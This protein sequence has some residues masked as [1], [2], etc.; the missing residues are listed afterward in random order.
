MTAVDVYRITDRLDSAT[1]EVLETRLE[2]RGKHPRFL[3]M[4]NEYLDAMGIDGAARVLDVGCGTGVVAR[5]IARRAGFRGRVTGIDVS[6]RLIDAARRIAAAESL[7]GATA[8]HAGDSQSLQ[9]ADASFDA[10]IAHTLISHVDSPAAVLDEMARVVRPGGTIAVFDGD[11]ASITFGTD[12]PAR[13]RA[14]DD[15]II[16]AIVTNPRVMREMPQLLRAA[17]LDLERSFA[18]V[19]AEVG[20]ADF[21][22]GSIQSFMKLIPKS[23]AATE[24]DVADWAEEVLRRSA[25]GVFF[26]ACNFYSHIAKRR[27]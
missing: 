25:R 12:D 4:M 3:H 19:L 9:L 13:G 6:P 1:L 10:V 20:T 17:G 14:M 27:P 16:A 23:G 7:A 5:T 8:F 11:Y 24:A 26:G 2:A 15:A 18:H 22:T 21:W